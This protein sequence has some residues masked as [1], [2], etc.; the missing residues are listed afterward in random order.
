M[1]KEKYMQI[2]VNIQIDFL[3]N[4][5][6]F[7]K[8]EWGPITYVVG[9]NGTGKSVFAERLKQQ[10]KGKGLK[11]RYFNADRIANLASKWDTVGYLASDRTSKGLDIG[12]FENYK[13]KAD[14]LGQSIDALIELQSKLDL[15]I[16]VESIL[17]DVFQKE[18]TFQEKGGFLNIVLT[19]KKT[20]KAYDFKKNESH[21]LK[22]IITLLTFIYNDD[23]NCIILDEPELNLHPQF[24]Q[25]ILQEIKKNAGEPKD[26]KKIFVILTHSPYMLDINNSDDLLNYILFHKEV[27]PSYITYYGLD[28]YK[29]NRLNRLLLRINTNHKTMFFASSPVF[30]EG[31]IDQQLLNLIESKRDIPLGA[32]GISIIDV[33]GKDEVDIMYSLCLKLGIS[34]KAIVDLDALFEGKLRQTIA[35]LP[36]ASAYL[37]TQGQKD[38][39]A[40]IGELQ[41]LVSEIAELLVNMDSSTLSDPSTEFTAF[42]NTLKGVTGEKA[43]QIKRRLTLLAIQRIYDEISKRLDVQNNTK[44]TRAKSLS[45]HI[46]NCLE[47][48]NVFVLA[49]GE[50]ENYY[51][52]Y[53]ENQYSIADNKKTDYFLAEYDAINSLS[54][55]QLVEQYPEIIALLD[56]ICPVTTIDTKR[57]ISIKLSD[58]I[59]AVQSLFQANNSITKELIETHP[60]IQWE[61]YKRIIDLVEFTSDTKTKAFTCKFK[62]NSN[63]VSD[64]DIVYEFTHNTVPSL[65]SI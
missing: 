7:T 8:S 34:A 26:G 15:Q 11:V 23:Y 6:H 64:S 37:A 50:I 1:T 39:M 22:E 38:L 48:S 40:T 62:I 52:T 56:K 14:E 4:N 42:L 3:W 21:G 47:N 25:F 16:K 24:Q 5:Q 44:L 35:E 28:E 30:V 53:T 58:W 10:F 41:T 61:K 51:T 29:L 59:H 54:K 43:T 45:A 55:S 18:L 27:P 32:E 33:G 17:S 20:G 2:P 36:A 49:K 60:K 31:Y 57:M 9:A 63:M 19:D 46:L 13:S 12:N 65:F